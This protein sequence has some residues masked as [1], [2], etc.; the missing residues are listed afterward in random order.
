MIPAG[1][2]YQGHRLRQARK[3]MGFSC[4]KLAARVMN[5]GIH[6][7]HESIRAWEMGESEPRVTTAATIA[8]L[9]H[10][11]LDWFFGPRDGEAS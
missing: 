5:H 6:V 3:A 7:N 1:Y 8:W 4:F 10:R 2:V 11:D 9:L